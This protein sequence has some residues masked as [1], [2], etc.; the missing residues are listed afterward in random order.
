M[1]TV[2]E[3]APAK[4][5]PGQVRFPPATAAIIKATPTRQTRH[6][7]R[8]QHC[9]S[10]SLRSYFHGQGLEQTATERYGI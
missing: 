2:T 7:N 9:G 10:L 5:S 1:P 6:P 3:V 4:I 8:S